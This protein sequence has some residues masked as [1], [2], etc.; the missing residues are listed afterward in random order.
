VIAASLEP[1]APGSHVGVGLVSVGANNEAPI[2]RVPAGTQP[3][4]TG[5]CGG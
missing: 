3:P 2:Y 1:D 4:V 5:Q